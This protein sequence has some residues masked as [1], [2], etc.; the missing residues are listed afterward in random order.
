VRMSASSTAVCAYSRGSTPASG[1]ATSHGLL[2]AALDSICTAALRT[3]LRG[4]PG[5]RRP[6]RRGAPAGARTGPGQT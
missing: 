2:C 5:L 4:G 3:C 1:S 6:R